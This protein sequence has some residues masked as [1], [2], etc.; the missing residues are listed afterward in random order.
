MVAKKNDTGLTYKDAGVNIDAGDALID[1]IKPDAKRT[2]RP[3]ANPSLGGFGGLFDL[4]AAGYNDPILV[5]GTDGVGTK[6]D[7]AQAMNYHR[8][9]GIDLV[10]MCSNDFGTGRYAA[11]FP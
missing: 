8:T 11:V 3:G 6:L 5:S 2:M 10:A 4:K 9:L 7:I 1:A